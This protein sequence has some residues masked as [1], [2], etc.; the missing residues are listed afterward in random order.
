MGDGD[1]AA[2]RLRP[3]TAARPDADERLI[4]AYLPAEPSAE[5]EAN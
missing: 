3:G 4:G 5:P 1:D 2:G